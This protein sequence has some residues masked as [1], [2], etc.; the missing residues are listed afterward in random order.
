MTTLKLRP[1]CAAITL[2]AAHGAFAQV[3]TAEPPAAAPAPGAA[4]IQTVQITGLRASIRSAEEIKRD[5]EQVVD[6]INAEDIG[7]F[8]TPPPATPC[9]ASPACR[10]GATWARPAA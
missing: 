9:S 10:W 4:P 7:K 1:V 6:S 5:A 3:Q 8:P 2:L